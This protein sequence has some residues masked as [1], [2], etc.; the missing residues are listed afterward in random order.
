MA[1]LTP[2]NV[3]QGETFKI[4]VT[5]IQTDPNSPIDITEY[6]ISGQV[7]ENYTTDEVAAQ[8]GI[9]KMSPYESGS[10]VLELDA[11]Q[12]LALTERKYVYDI[13]ASSGSVA[14]NTRRL[15]EGPFTVR[16]AVTR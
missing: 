14:D 1:E 11:T 4:L 16:P 7:R 12:T 15:L 6:D 8:F 13:I 10:F 9:T 3:G 5:L 2:L